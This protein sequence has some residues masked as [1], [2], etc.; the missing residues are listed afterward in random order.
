[1]PHLLLI[2]CP[3]ERGLIYK[4]TGILYARGLNILRN[5]EFVEREGN[6]FFMRTEFELAQEADAAPLLAEVRAALPGAANVRL[7]DN[8]R[9]NI[10]L[11]ATKEHHCLSELLVR[12]AFNELNANI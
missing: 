4:I 1:M 11:L 7:T 5:S 12:H 9:K 8:R 3:D 2:Q 10:V 6:V